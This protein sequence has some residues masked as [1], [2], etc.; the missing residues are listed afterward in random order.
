MVHFNHILL[1]DVVYEMIPT[2][3]RRRTHWNVLRQL[4]SESGVSAESL[5]V[6]A[7]CGASGPTVAEALPIVEEAARQRFSIDFAADS[8][9]LW[10]HAVDLHALAG[11][12]DPSAAIVDRAGMVTAMC[13]L[14]TALA[15]RGEV[16]A[17]RDRRRQ[18]VRL[19]ESIGDRSI[20]LAAL[21]CWRTPWIWATEGKGTLDEAMAAA[22]ENALVDAQGAERVALLVASVLEYELSLIHI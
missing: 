6:H 5:A 2:L 7:A 10:Q 15:H 3:R 17:A 13:N 16:T 1:R 20:L 22:L 4:Q 11:H 18:A 14:T 19:A 9:E 12:D 8:T 21:T